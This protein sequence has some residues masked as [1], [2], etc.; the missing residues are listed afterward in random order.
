MLLL[1]G[2]GKTSGRYKLKNG[3]CKYLLYGILKS[4]PLFFPLLGWY[5]VVKYGI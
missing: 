1:K 4:F 2:A 3:F 5:R